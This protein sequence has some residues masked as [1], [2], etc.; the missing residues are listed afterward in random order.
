MHHGEERTTSSRYR[1]SWTGNCAALL[2][3]KFRPAG[4]LVGAATEVN[5]RAMVERTPNH[6]ALERYVRVSE[7]LHERRFETSERAL[8]ELVT[9]LHTWTEKLRLERLSA[10]GLDESEVDHVVANSRGS[11]MKTNP[12]VLTDEEIKKIL[13]KRL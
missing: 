4:T 11:S 1:Y 2:R 5:V 12:I 7:V 6:P 10:Y 13:L 3:S 9:L 8:Q